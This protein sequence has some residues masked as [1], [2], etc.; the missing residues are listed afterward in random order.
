MNDFL[1]NH[2]FHGGILIPLSFNQGYDIFG[3]YEY[4][5]FRVDLKAR[6]F[7]K[8]IVEKESSR[9]V[10]QRYNLDRFEI[11]FKL[12]FT[13][14]FRVE[15]NPFYSQTRYLDSDVRLFIPAN[16]STQFKPNVVRRYIG[17]NLGLIYDNSVVTGTNIHEGTR[18]KII[19]D[20]HLK[21]NS[22]AE[23]FSN[24]EVDFR[25]YQRLTKGL[26]VAG[27]VHFGSYFG[28]VQAVPSGWCRQ[29]G[30]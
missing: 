18:A 25:H 11:G 28:D 26:L 2:R 3:E 24:V 23:N 19:L 1:E 7:R 6:Y 16:N 20:S 22:N 21:A 5:K 27:M 13:Q 10:N 29:L 17:Y 15:L 12:P 9:F 4:L 30:F 8:S 14:R